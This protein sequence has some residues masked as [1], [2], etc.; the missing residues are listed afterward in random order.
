MLGHRIT[1]E[2]VFPVP[3]RQWVFTIPKRLRIYFRFDRSLLG[4]LCRLAYES[5]RDVMCSE[6]GADGGLPGMIATVQTFGDLILWHCHVHAIISEGVFIKDGS[7]VNM[8]DVDLAKCVAR[9]QKKVFA[10]LV[11]K[12]KIELDDAQVNEQVGALGIRHT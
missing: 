1:E 2:I 6:P 5:V 12:K 11:H 7:F 8:P 9:W 10:L 4:N 3:H